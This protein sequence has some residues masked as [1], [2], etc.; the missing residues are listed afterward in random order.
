[1]PD[2]YT[3]LLGKIIEIGRL[4]AVDALIQWDQDTYMPQKGVNARAEMCAQIA[5]TSH[6]LQTS[7]ALGELISNVEETGEPARD[8]NIRE[9]KRNYER[10][11][12]LPSELVEQ[13]SRASSLAKSA[14]AQ[15][16]QENDFPAFAPHLDELLKLA[17]QKA[18]AIGF[19]GE[20]YDALMDEYEPGAKSAD[21]GD[22]FKSL[23]GALVPLVQSI[24]NST[25]PIDDEIIRRHYPEAAQEELCK[26]LASAI[27]FDFTA[28][29][30][31]RS[32]HPFCTSMGPRDVRVTTRFD[33][34][35]FSPAI[36]GVLHEVG[37]GL[38]EQGLDPAHQFTPM[39]TATSL[40]I[41]ESQSRLWENMV[42]RSLAFWKHHYATAQEYFPEAL[43]D[44]PLEAFYRAIN[45]SA[46]SLIRVEADEV[47]YNLH[48]IMRFELE[49]EL[50]AGRLD[51][52]DVPA[53]W[54]QKAEEFLGLTP[55]N[56]ADGCLQ[57]IHWSLGGFGYFPT[58][59][60]GNLYA[61]QFYAKADADLGGL[62]AQIARGE[63]QPLR[64]WLQENI[65]SHGMRYR[66]AELCE[67]VTGQRLS[68]DAFMDYLNRKYKSL[69]SLA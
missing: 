28:G 57:D 66:A 38:Y 42:G 65:H 49:R 68:I 67:Q 62:E 39:G 29:R 58:Y 31:D 51:V 45:K 13:L 63:C 21:I 47:T 19:E 30:L 64:M 69:Y 34:R 4:T 1:M 8:T 60:L 27:C 41:H 2:K 16:R 26:H 43:G 17:R 18:D 61:A 40:G 15:A 3:Q 6:Q 9:A 59:A 53:A 22:L 56:D 54:N 32:V 10:A 46:P 50:I 44:V 25:N 48:I 14:W 7:D 36:F 20:R 55:P 12:R 37:H 11:S 23:R 52:K 5:I 35:F 24:A 33:E